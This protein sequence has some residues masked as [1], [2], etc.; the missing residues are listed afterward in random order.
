MSIAVRLGQARHRLRQALGMTIV[1]REELT[2]RRALGLLLVVALVFGGSFA[3]GQSAG[4]D[5]AATSTDNQS[6]S[7]TTL[8]VAHLGNEPVIPALL[9]PK[10]RAPA[11][12]PAATPT[13]AITTTSPGG[14]TTGPAT[15]VTG[16]APSAPAPTPAPA[17]ATPSKPGGGSFDD[18]G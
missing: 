15:P 5:G 10:P 1:P 14:F 11:A 13:A 3:L 8:T 7:G 18:S 9:V 17:P 4:S 12:R 6:A 16:P 2:P